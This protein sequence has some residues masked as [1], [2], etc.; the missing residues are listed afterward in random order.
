MSYTIEPI[1]V[2]YETDNEMGRRG[3]CCGM[4]TTERQAT[5]A[6]AGKGYYGSQ[7]SVVF[8][9]CINIDGKRFLLKSPE[10]IEADVDSKTFRK[11]QLRSSALAKLTPQE[12]EALE[13]NEH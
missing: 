1:Y 13:L 2:A 5:A 8:E 7:G 6:A 12:I 10:P 3:G 11:Q 9:T 4:F